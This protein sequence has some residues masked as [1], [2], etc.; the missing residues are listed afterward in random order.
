ME[1]LR[2]EPSAGSHSAG[3]ETVSARRVSSGE[4]V[5]SLDPGPVGSV[6]HGYQCGTWLSVWYMTIS[7]VHDYQCGT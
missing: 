4:S 1:D 3:L 7:V 5:V 6:V 2:V